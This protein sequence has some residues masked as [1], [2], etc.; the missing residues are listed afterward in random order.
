MMKGAFYLN[1]LLGGIHLI[2]QNVYAEKIF[3]S[4]FFKG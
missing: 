3:G 2:L 1:G 4:A